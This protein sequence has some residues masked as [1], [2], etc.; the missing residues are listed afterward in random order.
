MSKKPLLA[1]Q[2][3]KR[4]DIGDREGHAELA[5]V[6]RTEMQEPVLHAEAAAIRV[7]G[8]LRGG[9][10]HDAL[11]VIVVGARPGVPSPP[12]GI[13]PTYRGTKLVRGRGQDRI[14]A[15]LRL[16]DRNEIV[17]EPCI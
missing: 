7:V 6:T 4:A 9:E 5:F 12:V 2:R 17:R 3:S 10:L 1:L 11:F 14:R 15:D 8:H 13:P 16:A